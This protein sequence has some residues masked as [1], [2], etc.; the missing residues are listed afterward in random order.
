MYL[1]LAFVSCHLV[2]FPARVYWPSGTTGREQ[3]FLNTACGRNFYMVD[4][5]VSKAWDSVDK[6]H[7]LTPSGSFNQYWIKCRKKIFI[8]GPSLSAFS[9]KKIQSKAFRQFVYQ[10]LYFHALVF[11]GM[12]LGDGPQN[13]HIF[14]VQSGSMISNHIG[15]CHLRHNIA[16]LAL[17][18]AY[19]FYMWVIYLKSPNTNHLKN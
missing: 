16:Q 19:N 10:F 7:T 9:A 14:L 6:L 3:S 12:A 5:L 4:G 11:S 2:L 17:C 8:V 13:W 15:I 18:Y 1:T